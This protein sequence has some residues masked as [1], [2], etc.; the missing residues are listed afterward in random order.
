[1]AFRGAAASRSLLA[2]V[3]GRAA[4]SASRLR[5]AVPSPPRLA[6]ALEPSPPRPRPSPPQDVGGDDGV[7]RGCRGEADRA[8][9][10]RAGVLGAL[11]GAKWER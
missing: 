11:P 1:M 6:A 10:E 7:A 9:G 8:R 3:R 2:A 5:A 4:S